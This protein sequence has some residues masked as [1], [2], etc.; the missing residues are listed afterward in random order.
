VE[1]CF[2][3][4]AWGGGGGKVKLW[5]NVILK[6]VTQLSITGA[7]RSSAA[8]HLLVLLRVSFGGFSFCFLF[9]QKGLSEQG[10]GRKRG[11]RKFK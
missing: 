10:N 3:G 9:N 8:P 5:P 1:V 7:V 2:R 4:E 11:R 6:N